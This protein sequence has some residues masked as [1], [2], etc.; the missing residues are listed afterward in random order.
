MKTILATAAFAATLAIGAV[1]TS[2]PAA[3]DAPRTTIQKSG[4]AMST[5]ISAQR[6][7]YRG[8]YRGYYGG[9]R[10]YGP[11]YYGG[12][13][14]RPYRPYYGGY[15]YRPYGGYYGRPAIGFGVGPFG[16]GVF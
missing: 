7:Y 3:A 2:A 8:G 4:K 1:A 9:P 15:G 5:D 13:Y 6:R 11:R 12:G 10:Y 14:Y 16:F